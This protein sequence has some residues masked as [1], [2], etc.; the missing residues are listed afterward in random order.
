[1]KIFLILLIV[2]LY[3]AIKIE[4]QNFEFRKKHPCICNKKRHEVNE[5]CYIHKKLFNTIPRD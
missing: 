5:Y 1:M 3:I 4:K 2:A